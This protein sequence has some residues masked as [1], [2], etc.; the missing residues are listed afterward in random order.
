MRISFVTGVGIN[1]SPFIICDFFV[2][3]VFLCFFCKPLRA[4]GVAFCCAF[5][6][7]DKLAFCGF[8]L[9]LP[10]IF[11]SENRHV[12]FSTC[13]FAMPCSIDITLL[14]I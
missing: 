3:E 14:E 1:F 8:R 6:W 10:E 5:C 12:Y 7:I 9:T 11:E 13:L 4:Y 2:R